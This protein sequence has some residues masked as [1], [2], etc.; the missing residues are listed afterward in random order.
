MQRVSTRCCCSHSRNNIHSN[1]TG[2]TTIGKRFKSYPVRK[3]TP[4]ER[5]N[6]G[7]RA[8]VVRVIKP[9]NEHAI[10]PVKEA[11]EMAFKLNMD[12][13][14]VAPNADPPVC[15]I[16]D[17][18]KYLFEKKKKEKEA[19]KK[20]HV[21]VLKELRFRPQTDDHDYEFK[22]RHAEGFLKEGNK[23]KATVQFKGRDIIYSDQGKKLLDRLAEDLEDFGKVETPAKLE[24]KRMSMVVAP[25]K[26]PGS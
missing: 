5:V 9:D 14:E 24:G 17:H 23:V 3:S 15:K 2:E 13:V 4:K 20:Q 22:K 6:E 26:G 19:K 1:Q 18:G 7:I 11:I 8:D 21:V 16:M 25:T 12:L 10:L